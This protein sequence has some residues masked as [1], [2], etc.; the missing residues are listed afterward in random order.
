[1]DEMDEPL[2]FSHG[3]NSKK[4]YVTRLEDAL[5]MAICIIKNEAGLKAINSQI[6]SAVRLNRWCDELIVESGIDFDVVL[7]RTPEGI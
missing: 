1:M 7:S 4:D 2:F 6:G 5:C 3:K